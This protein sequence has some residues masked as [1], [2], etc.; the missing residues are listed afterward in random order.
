MTATAISASLFVSTTAFA[1][2][3]QYVEIY[4]ATD[5]SDTNPG[6][7]ELPLQTPQAAQAKV[8]ELKAN[9]GLGE[10]GTI[11]Y[12]REGIYPLAST[13]SFTA[14]DSGT[15]ESPIT[16]RAYLE[17]EVQFIG[18]F[19]LKPEDFTK[20]KDAKVLN[21]LI[22]EDAREELYELDLKKYGM[23]KVPTPRLVGTYSYWSA[24]GIATKE[25]SVIMDQLVAKLG[26]LSTDAPTPELFI[27]DEIQSVSKYPNG[28]GVYMRV[29]TVLEAG[30]FMRNWNDDIIGSADW[31]PPEERVPTPFAFKASADIMDRLPYWQ[32]ANQALMWGRWW[33]DWATQ[34]VPLESVD[35]SSG[36]I[37]SAVPSSF[38][39]KTNQPWYIYNLLEEI[40]MPGEYFLDRDTTKLYIWLP[41][42][43]EYISSAVLTTLDGYIIGMN[44]A[45]NIN[46]HGIDVTRSRRGAFLIENAKNIHITDSEVSWTAQ[47]A[48][49]VLS[50]YDVTFKHGYIHDVD[51]GIRFQDGCGDLETL[52]RGNCGVE[53]T[54]ITRYARITGT[55]TQAAAIYG[56]GNFVRNCEI[57]DNVHLG[58]G[59]SG[60][61]Q[62]V[63]FNNIYNLCQQA[64]DTGVIYTGRSIPTHWGSE[65]KYNYIHD[66]SPRADVTFHVGT[67]AIYLDDFLSGVTVS[68]NIIEN[69]QKGTM[70]SGY[71][72]TI[73]N[74]I[75]IGLSDE[76]ILTAFG[77][78][79]AASGFLPTFQTQLDNATYK[80]TDPWKS[81]FPA[82]A[83]LNSDIIAK[84]DTSRGIIV[85]NNYFW[86]TGSMGLDGNVP[87]HEENIVVDNIVA[88]KDPGFIDYEGGNL[89]LKEDAAIYKQLPDF[90]PIPFT[91]IG[92]VE[93]RAMQRIAE[94]ITLIIDSPYVFVDGEKQLINENELGQMP[95]IKNNSTYVP[96]RFLGEALGTEVTFDDATRI[97]TFKNADYTL[98]FS[99]DELNKVTKNDEEITLDVP[100]MVIE[101]RTYMPLRAISE[102]INKQVFWDDCGFIT[103]SDIEDLFNS[104]ADD[105]VIDYLHSELSVY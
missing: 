22:S 26:Y 36:R 88:G 86:N 99:I 62:E 85:A 75:Y 83:A 58:V 70:F 82:L 5:G 14:E 32:N 35:P 54:E 84:D 34:S 73:T 38:S 4:V 79:P 47:M 92:L 91:R 66:C 102:M 37:Q 50:S 21:R 94:G 56:C 98:T 67:I 17:E 3:D 19:N 10:K 33:W 63:S 2:A 31:V 68:G 90:Q 11:V 101:G 12:F 51:G 48:I 87:M 103:V 64:D 96:F 104:E 29:E 39:V 55:Y 72:N 80:D 100:M 81:K 18:G 52:T 15:E 53:N 93:E 59:F 45:E 41:T 42:D 6:T 97:A 105:C 9:G 30:P 71:N 24:P 7:K 1:S 25:N 61:L 46:F 44:G 57:H 20:V 16:Y 13:L 43:P 8:R 74:N 77:A 40:D 65:V 78:N 76:P 49:D 27:N 60:P 69:M 28:D 23:T 95:I 89:Q